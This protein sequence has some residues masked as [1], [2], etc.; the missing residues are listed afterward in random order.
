MT[1]NS[2][3]TRRPGRI[4]AFLKEV[5]IIIVVALV[6][7]TVV[8][9][10][11]VR[12]FYI[13]SASME[14]T[15]QVGDR[16]LVNQLPWPAVERGDII[17]FDDPGGW[18]DSSV[19]QQYSPNPVLEFLGLVPAD[20]GT[21]L[22]KR[23][24]GVGGDTIECCDAEGRLLVNGEPIDETYLDPGITPSDIPFE[25]TVPDGHYWVMGDNRSN[26]LDSRFNTGSAGGAFVPE[27]AVV[28]SVF[29]INWPLDR[30]RG[31]GTPDEIFAAVPAP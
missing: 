29:L 7:S 3:E 22:I 30:I 6:I 5:A 28:G 17:V 14:Q 2:P 16:I 13:P 27:D 12:S 20:A 1:T 9:T 11:V 4:P 26:S 23:V 10:W 25:V 24:I 31:I 15:L 18:L 19:T 8:R 21:Q